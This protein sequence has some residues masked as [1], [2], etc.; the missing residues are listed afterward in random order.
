MRIKEILN[1]QRIGIDILIGNDYNYVLSILK[2]HTDFTIKQGCGIKN[3]FSNNTKYGNRCFFIERLDNT[4]VDISYIHA[5]KPKSKLDDIKS[6]CRNAIRPIIKEFIKNNF[7]GKCSVTGDVITYKEMHVDHYDMDFIDMF[8]IWIQSYDIDY[9][10][11]MINKSKDNVCFET[12]FIDEKIKSDFVSFH[13]DFT[14]LRC[15]SKK[16]N[17]SRNKHGK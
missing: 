8:N 7:N 15:V 17:L 16:F 9:L 3:I 1:R 13:N 10:Y 5:L 11:S 6:A 12:F 2:N 4:I 14:K